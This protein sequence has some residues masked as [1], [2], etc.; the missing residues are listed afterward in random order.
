MLLFLH[1]ACKPP[2]PAP[3]GLDAVTSYMVKEFYNEDE[4]FAAGIQGFMNW[5]DTEGYLLVGEAAG[6][7]NTDTFTLNDLKPGD[8]EH[9]P[10][11]DYGQDLSRAKGVISLAEMNCSWKEAEGYL[12]RKDQD[13]VFAGDWESYERTYQSDRNTFEQATSDDDFP[14]ISSPVSPFTND[15]NSD[16]VAKTLV[17]PQSAAQAHF[18]VLIFQHM[19]LFGLPSWNPHC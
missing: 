17:Y 7:G 2:P 18:W 16:D 15:F 3:E 6:D 4:R 9:L 12:L 11:E 5:F 8:V 14:E 13:A 10:I 1:L 19:I